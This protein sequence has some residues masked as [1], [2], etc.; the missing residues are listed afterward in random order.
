MEQA[1]LL[2][3]GEGLAAVSLEPTFALTIDEVMAHETAA[4]MSTEKFAVTQVTADCLGVH[5]CGQF[6][7]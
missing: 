1:C 6:R 7:G 3:S 2:V 5:L 4:E